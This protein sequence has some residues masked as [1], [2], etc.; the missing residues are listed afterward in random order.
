M[1]SSK[2]IPS[3]GARSTPALSTR[4][5]GQVAF[6]LIELLVVIAIIAILAAM[7]LPALSKAKDRAH[8]ISCLNNAKQLVTAAIIYQGDTGRSIDYNE[9]T[10][11]WMKSLVEAGLKV[12]QSRLC[13]VAASRTTT[14]V[15]QVGNAAA[16]WD[17]SVSGSGDT[18]LAGSYAINGWLYYYEPRPNG[19]WTA[20]NDVSKFFQ[21]DTAIVMPSQTPY[22]MDAIWPDL[23]PKIMHRLA[24]DL[25]YGDVLTSFG[26]VSIARHSLLRQARAIDGQPVPGAI[27]VSYADGHAGKLPLQKIKTVFWH[28]DYS[29]VEDPWKLVP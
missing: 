28:K 24:K 27:N 11:L 6:T 12:K 20:E 15:P 13:P 25:F 18:N 19:I 1:R 5:P 4:R 26:R 17:W 10:Q 29:P 2:R 22:F 3:F 16:P 21:K 14:S 9:I 8:Q 7:L 23:W